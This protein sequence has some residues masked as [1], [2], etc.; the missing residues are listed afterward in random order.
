MVLPYPTFMVGRSLWTGN[1]SYYFV[2]VVLSGSKYT[3]M[4][5]PMASFTRYV[6]KMAEYRH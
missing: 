5:G 4:V 2:R 1:G 3:I 6:I